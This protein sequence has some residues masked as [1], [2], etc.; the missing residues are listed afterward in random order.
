MEILIALIAAAA[1]VATVLTTGFFGYAGVRPCIGIKASKFHTQE[2]VDGYNIKIATDKPLNI[3]SVEASEGVMLYTSAK[4]VP[5]RSG[6]VAEW[7]LGGSGSRSIIP[8]CDRS[9]FGGEDVSF[10]LW[11]KSSNS[12]HAI[13]ISLIARSSNLPWRIKRNIPIE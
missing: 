1:A 11:I 6:W 5:D 7:E 10:P 9:L 13:R 12:E 8:P 2:G 4:P 3:L